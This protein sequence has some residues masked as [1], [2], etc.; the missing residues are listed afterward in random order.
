[1]LG[2]LHSKRAGAAGDVLRAA[3]RRTIL[4]LL[5]AGFVP[6]VAS[7]QL[8][9]EQVV[10]IEQ[11]GTAALSPDGRLVAYTLVKPRA[12]TEPFGPAWSELWV[13]AA[14]GG[15]A[16][17]IIQAPQSAS[18]PAWTPGGTAL[19]FVTRITEQHPQSQVYAVPAAGGQ[20]RALT[21]S[22]NGVIA[23]AYSPDGQ[24]IAYS[25]LEPGSRGRG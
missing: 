9:P 12:A 4:V 10:R 25:A 6:A 21:R 2:V 5:M 8:T 19:A 16:R 3:R 1:M 14:T 11:V 7:A 24:R 22:A 18:G 20:P 17:A 23:F 15:Q 13:V